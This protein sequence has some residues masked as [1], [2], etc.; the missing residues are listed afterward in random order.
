[1]GQQ[2]LDRQ[3]GNDYFFLPLVDDAK[4][5]VTLLRVDSTPDGRVRIHLHRAVNRAAFGM[6]FGSAADPVWQPEAEPNVT[7]VAPACGRA[8][9][10]EPEVVLA[11]VGGFLAGVVVGDGGINAWG[12]ES[13]MSNDELV[14]HLMALARLHERLEPARRSEVAED[15]RV[16]ARMQE[17]AESTNSHAGALREWLARAEEVA[18][19]VVAAARAQVHERRVQEVLED[20]NGHGVEDTRARTN[21]DL[22]RLTTD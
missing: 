6:R 12:F 8:G 17:I 3:R 10:T 18:E 9:L 16:V 20:L 15:H 11:E 5:S 1:M 22:P 21:P 19:D 4:D 14:L 7:L 13:L 2:P